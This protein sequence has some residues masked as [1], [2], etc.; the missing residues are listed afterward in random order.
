M[1]SEIVS[2][3]ANLRAALIRDLKEFYRVPRATDLERMSSFT[4][5]CTQYTGGWL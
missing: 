2:V 3:S 5:R 4:T 1:T